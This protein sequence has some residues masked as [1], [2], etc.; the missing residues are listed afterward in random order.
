ML[1]SFFSFGPSRCFG[2]PWSLVSDSFTHSHLCAGLE[3]CAFDPEAWRH[4]IHK[5]ERKKK[6]YTYQNSAMHIGYRTHSYQSIVVYT[7]LLSHTCIHYTC[8]KW[9]SAY[10]LW[11][12]HELMLWQL[13]FGKGSFD[14]VWLRAPCA[15]MFYSEWIGMDR[16]G[17]PRHPLQ[18]CDSEEFSVCICRID[19]YLF[20]CGGVV[21]D[22]FCVH[23]SHPVRS[24]KQQLNY[25]SA[26]LQN[27]IMRHI[28]TLCTYVTVHYKLS[29]PLTHPDLS[30]L[31]IIF[32]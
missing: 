21:M 13:W 5:Q 8:S 28:L 1:S 15:G 10:Y 12:V 30:I 31:Y 27:I 11:A 17:Q 7:N 23:W 19:V 2:V 6:T 4:H 25:K 20:P 18:S 22:F 9:C 24:H 14:A 3:C 26:V 29:V 32:P 16:T